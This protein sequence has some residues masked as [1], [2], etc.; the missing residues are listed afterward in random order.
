MAKKLEPKIQLLV[1][2]R[3]AKEAVIAHR[4]GADLIDVKEPTRGP[5]GRADFRVMQDVLTESSIPK[6]VPRTVALGELTEGNL[7]ANLRKLASIGVPATAKLGFS[8]VVTSTHLLRAFAQ[9]AVTFRNEVELVPVFY[10]DHRDIGCPRFELLLDLA[11]QSGCKTILID[12]FAKDGRKL[13][14]WMQPDVLGW[15]VQLAAAKN[16]RVAAAGSLGGVSLRRLER[17]FPA[18]VGVRG[19]VCRNGKRDGQL[20]AE[21]ISQTK[22][23]LAEVMNPPAAV[24]EIKN[25][26]A[27]KATRKKAVRSPKQPPVKKKAK[28]RVVVKR[29]KSK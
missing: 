7:I 25:P 3:N 12:T 6:E 16:I 5:M 10:A 18:I 22:A 27:K 19:S 14:N 2:V 24:E 20:D 23:I 17:P 21:L 26:P 28:P 8:K 11:E 1:S 13:W 29:P 15:L 4:G 9:A